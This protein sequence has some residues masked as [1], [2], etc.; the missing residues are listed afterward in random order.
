VRQR[1]QE[2]HERLSIRFPIYLLVTKCDLLAGFMDNFG[3]LDK[4]QRAAPW[5]F[6][7]PISPDGKSQGPALERFQL[8]FDA[9]LQRLS[10]G[11]IDRLQAEADP[12]RRARIYSFPGQFAGLRTM[13]QEFTEAVFSPS[14]FEAEPMLRGVY[15]VSGTQEGTP[16]DRML[17][18]IARHYQLERAILPPQQSSG[19]SYFLSRLLGEVVFAEHGLAGTNQK[20]ERGRTALSVAGY[21]VVGVAAIGMLTAWTLSYRNNLRYVEKV[22]ARVDGVRKLVQETPNRADPDLLPV[23]GALEA[24]RSLAAAGSGLEDGKVPLSLGFGL[25]QGRKL[26]GVA[27]TVYQRMLVDAVLPRLALRAAEQLRSGSQPESEYEALKVYL[28]MYD[29]THFDEKAVKRYFEAD[30][31]VRAGRDLSLEGREQLSRHLD[32]LLAQGAA[33]SPL[34]MDK[35][36]V[37]GSRNRLAAVPLPQR[38]YNRMRQQGFGAEFKDFTI[39]AAGGGNAP[40]VFT[41]ASGKPLTQG[42]PG[43]FSYDGYHKGFQSRVGDVTKQLADEQEWVLGTKEPTGKG[44]NVLLGS[45]KMVDDVRRLYLNDYATEW[46]DFIADIRLVPLRSVAESA[47]A[48]QVLAASDTPLKPLLRSMSKETTLLAGGTLQNAKNS[49]IDKL[50]T[51]SGK[52]LGGTTPTN[53]APGS[54]IES[55]VDDRF[56]KLRSMV[57]APEG[58]KA[59]L[60]GLVERLAELQ[61][62]LNAVDTAGKAGAPPPTSPLPNQLRVDAANSPEPLRSMLDTLGSSG[63]RSALSQLRESLS[64]EVRSQLGEFCQQAIAGRYPLDRGATRE[65]TQADFAAVFGPG[66]RFDQVM[67]KLAP[68]V[69]TSTRPWSFRAIDGTPLGTDSGTLPQFQRAQIIKETFFPTGNTASLRLEFKPVEMDQTITQFTLD[70]D[71][72]LV[73]YSHGPQIPAAV[74]WPGPRGTGVVR[75]MLTPG[76]SAGLVNDGPWALFRMFERVNFQPLPGA[77]AEKFRAQF[78][79]EGRKAL[80]DVTASSV[81]NPFRLPELNAFQCPQSL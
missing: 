73:R 5:G 60:D 71:G 75:V 61:L 13:L 10:D 17:G 36:L 32:T 38:V 41:R 34:A 44:V 69:D 30:W 53:A 24:T 16:I 49:V 56:A 29:P 59:P 12:Q 77:S 37:D 74:Q 2:L 67:Q 40:L 55:I 4:D 25:Y 22:S 14:N 45:E 1:V 6:T 19:K 81:R 65:V 78:D 28:M 35:S 39:A 72:Q 26:D 18:S 46:S 57:T 51:E 70:V 15:F 27:Q 7:F 23:L 52:L 50:K 66:G 64:R 8:E 76:G 42:V 3:A 20:W 79:I 33:V 47:R 58:G 68:Y 62:F 43:L 9:L 48:A 11:L 54:R 21:A 63:S 31:D 80:F